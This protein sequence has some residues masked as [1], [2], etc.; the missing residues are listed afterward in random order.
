MIVLTGGR[1]IGAIC[2]LLVTLLITR[3]FG[4]QIMAHYS[5]F[6]SAA[7]ILSVLLPCGFHAIG[8]MFCAEYKAQNRHN[9]LVRFIEYSQ[10]IIAIAA[11][12]LAP[13]ALLFVFLGE[14]SFLSGI[15][16]QNSTTYD[17]AAIVLMSVPTATAMAYLYLNGGVLTGVQKQ[18]AGQLP[19]MTLRPILLLGGMM[20]LTLWSKQVSPI[21]VMA[22]SCTMF[23]IAAIVQW[24]LLRT[25][26]RQLQQ[27]AFGE[28]VQAAEKEERQKWWK[29]A[30]NWV[31]ITLLW[32]YFFEIHMLLAGFIVGPSQVALLYVCFRIRQLAGFGMRAL[33][34]LL[35]P[36]IFAANALE[37]TDETT[38]MIRLATRITLVYAIIIWLGTALVGPYILAL[39]GEE[40]KNGQPILLLLM[41]TLVVRAVFGPAP[42]IL[43]MKRHPG[44]VAKILTLSLGVSLLLTVTGFHYGGFTM[45]AGAYLVATAFTAIAMWVVAKQK[46]GINCAVWA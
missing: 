5:L 29:Q 44:I 38:S 36:K 13:V 34:S 20:L 32:D 12:V 2:I 6:L 43:G 7:S 40:F 37:N 25:F 23:W 1:I 45:I 8:P 26:L 3:S 14:T 9:H 19:D 18:F 42:A 46:T 11:I 16:N 35:L 17:I 15:F 41:G 10:K 28:K 21:Q 33:Y 22:M 30:P 39:F 27:S 4:A 24:V 31:T